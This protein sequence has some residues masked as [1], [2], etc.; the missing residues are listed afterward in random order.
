MSYTDD[1]S[2]QGSSDLPN[3]SYDSNLSVELI[4]SQTDTVQRASVS[5]TCRQSAKEN[6]IDSQKTEFPSEPRTKI[7]QLNI[8]YDSNSSVEIHDVEIL[9]QNPSKCTLKFSYVVKLV[10][11]YNAR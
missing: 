4:D 6:I 9:S 7:D 2:N 3:V 11:K 8:S 10:A 5:I 1:S